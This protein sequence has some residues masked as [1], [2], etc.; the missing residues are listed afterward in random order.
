METKTEYLKAALELLKFKAMRQMAIGKS[1]CTL[2]EDD[3]NEILIVA[4]LPVIT[5]ESFNK[6][7]LEVI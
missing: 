1:T 4:G 3:V 5:P 6:K 2:N 7:E